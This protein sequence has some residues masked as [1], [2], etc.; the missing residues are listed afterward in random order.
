M[1]RLS[2]VHAIVP[3]RTRH[4]AKSR[5]G[6]ALDAEEREILVLGLLVNTLRTLAAWKPLR[7][8]HVV[9]ADSD[10]AVVRSRIAASL[11]FVRDPAM[12][13]NE[14]L[15][16]GRDAAVAAGA[17]AVLMLPAD[18]PLL[19]VAA[20]DRLLDAADAALVAGSGRPV[21]VIVPA[22]ARAGTNGLL[23]TPPNVIEPHFGVASFEAHLRAASLVDASVQ[24]VD[25]ARLGFDLDTPDDLERLELSRQ[26]ELQAM[27][28]ELA[29]EFMTA[30]HG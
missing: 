6:I 26:L 28:E 2:R 30:T 20:L 19:D 25:D 4:E 18:L 1:A 12:D 13:L 14:A 9:A 8:L 22:D 5:L 15:R 16:A 21:A 3:I 10:L 23:L 27:G 17:T 24:V 7:T 29:A 11:N